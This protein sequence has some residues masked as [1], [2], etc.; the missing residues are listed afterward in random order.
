M[1]PPP[2][3]ALHQHRRST[4]LHHRFPARVAM[5]GERLER[6]GR[7]RTA[8]RGAGGADHGD[9]QARHL[10][11]QEARLA[12]FWLGVGGEQQQQAG[13]GGLHWGGLDCPPHGCHSGGDGGLQQRLCC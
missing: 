12:A 3:N 13:S 10:G 2:C 1:S 8:G 9:Q 4:L 11:E 6:Q 5:S 7:S